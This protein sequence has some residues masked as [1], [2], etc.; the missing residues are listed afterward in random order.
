MKL[1]VAEASNYCGGRLNDLGEK[2]IKYVVSGGSDFDKD[3][4]SI[5]G[6]RQTFD[7][8]VSFQ[9]VE[10]AGH[11]PTRDVHVG[12]DGADGH[13]ATVSLNDGQRIE[14]GVGQTMTTRHRRNQGFGLAPH[15]FEFSDHASRQPGRAGELL[16]ERRL[17]RWVRRGSAL[18]GAASALRW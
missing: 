12:T 17:F 4:T 18:T 9:G 16:F 14:C 8:A 10:H 3:S 2:S 5:A 6:I 15:G 7:E 1:L 11:C 13:G